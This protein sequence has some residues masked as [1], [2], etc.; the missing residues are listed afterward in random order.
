MYKI[1]ELLP[2]T[3]EG[4]LRLGLVTIEQMV[5]ALLVAVENP[6]RGVKVLNVPDIRAAKE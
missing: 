2:V 1:A 4:A 3:R 6:A 5:T